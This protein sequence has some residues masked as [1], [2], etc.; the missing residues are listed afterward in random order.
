MRYRD[1]RSL[2]AGNGSAS[3]QI[4]NILC[5]SSFFFGMFACVQSWSTG[6][7]RYV[8]IANFGFSV[9]FAILYFLSRLFGLLKKSWF[10]GP[11]FLIFIYIP[12]IWLFNGGTS[13]GTS[14]VV[15]LLD[16][17][18]VVLATGDE[19]RFRERILVIAAIMLLIA[20]M[21]FLLWLEYTRP[22]L[23]YSF[24]NRSAQFVDIAVSMLIAVFGN[25]L[26]LRTYVSMHQRDY[27][28]IQ[29]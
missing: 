16:S 28:S 8:V 12:V 19:A 29:K 10:A 2:V 9:F 23:V 7:S 3:S 26:I 13:S 22:E 11:I 27:A 15:I 20:V 5:F 25:F 4:Y 1:L 18:I 14:Y 24:E 17:F 6:I 21:G